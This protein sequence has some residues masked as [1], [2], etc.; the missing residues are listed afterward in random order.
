MKCKWDKTVFLKC[1]F[2]L[3]QEFFSFRERKEGRER[4]TDAR[5]RNTDLLPPYVPGQGIRDWGS[6]MESATQACAPPKKQTC[7]SSV[8]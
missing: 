6:R 2:N 1:F 4:N 5:E 7:N 8:T 3:T